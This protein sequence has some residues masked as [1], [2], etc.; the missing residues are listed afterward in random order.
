MSQSFDTVP[1]DQK[2]VD[3]VIPQNIWDVITAE[4]VDGSPSKD[5]E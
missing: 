4:V 3:H 5:V 2:E 1:D